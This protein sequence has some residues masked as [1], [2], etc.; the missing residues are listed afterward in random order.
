MRG[1]LILAFTGLAVLVVALYA[2]PRAVVVTNLIHRQ[3]QH[4]VNDTAALVAHF[5]DEHTGAVTTATL[6]SINGDYEWIVVRR[7]A[8]R[9]STTGTG[10]SPVGD[11]TAT[12]ALAGGGTV[13]VGLSAPIV[14]SAVSDELVPLIGLG[15]GI[16]VVAGV[17]GYLMAWRLARP[18][19]QLA[20]AASG[21]GRGDLH[22]DLPLYRMPELRSISKALTSSGA[23][24]ETMLAQERKLAVHA[25]HELRT[26]LAALRLELEDLA[27]W[28]ETPAAVVAQLHQAT[29]ELD[30]LANAIEDLL[31]LSKQRL[32][33]EEAHVDL[34]AFVART[35]SRLP[36]DASRVVV[37]RNGPVP[38]RLGPSPLT[39]LVEG[40]IQAQLA[41]GAERVVVNTTDKL[42]HVELA[43]RPEGPTIPTLEVPVKTVELAAS[44]GGQ[45]SRDQDTLVLRLPPHSRTTDDD[46]EVA[47]APTTYQR[48]DNPDDRHRSEQALSDFA[49][50]VSHDL[51]QPLTA[52]L[53][54]A[55][56][57]LDEPAIADDPE[58]LKLAQATFA[59][60]GRM[61]QLI[62][63]VL[64]YAR[65]G[66][67]LDRVDISLDGMIERIRGDLDPTPARRG[68]VV[69]AEGLPEVRADRQQLHAV[70]QNLIASTA[71][72]VPMDRIPVVTVSAARDD[73]LWRISVADDGE[74]L[75][76]EHSD[77]QSQASSDGSMAVTAVGW[78]TVQRVI[79]AHGGTVGID[80]VPEG[81][82]SIWF[83]LPA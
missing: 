59:A 54:N 51:R 19:Q 68:V 45:I 41:R 53:A 3:E 20:D 78:A 36:Q 48:L 27:L 25:S 12:R 17:A 24:L 22:P 4:R 57:L 32:E 71:K 80:Q 44:L 15:L 66:A 64:A 63:T 6:D 26:P 35:V 67:D 72:F 73:G 8:T 69:R 37:E 75:P 58:V 62:D 11:V 40:L 65:A 42:T 60:G 47:S 55:E 1:R 46:T 13:T 7:G 33:R 34:E 10:S 18:L 30:R 74:G 82:I 9:V 38:A 31:H 77:Q 29:S 21:L 2:V 16:L 76:R 52:I 50:H 81:G 43:I 23:Q 56:L 83:T 39:Q 14:T 28:P 5:L 70:L 79:D 49:G 61:A